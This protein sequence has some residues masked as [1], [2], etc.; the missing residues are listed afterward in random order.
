MNKIR[1][2]IETLKTQLGWNATEGS[3]RKWWLSFELEQASR[4]NLILKLLKELEKRE[5]TLGEFFLAYVYSN[6]NNIQTNLEYLDA[7]IAKSGTKRP[8]EASDF[9]NVSI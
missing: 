1:E 8:L 3:A 2:E 5:V 4:P 9:K 6:V 7:A